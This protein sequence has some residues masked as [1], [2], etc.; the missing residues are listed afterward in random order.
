M[1]R[2]SKEDLQTSMLYDITTLLPADAVS[3]SS[4]QSSVNPSCCQSAV[5]PSSCQSAVNPPL[6]FANNFSSAEMLPG[7]GGTF[8]ANDSRFPHIEFG[9]DDIRFARETL[10]VTDVSRGLNR[11]K[12]KEMLEVTRG[13]ASKAEMGDVG[14]T[15]D[16]L[17]RD[18]G[19]GEELGRRE[20]I[21]EDN[22]TNELLRSKSSCRRAKKNRSTTGKLCSDLGRA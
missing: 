8:D 18:F 7:V 5:N 21:S 10:G 6:R 2:S 15:A 14:F 12:G 11:K 13:T 20:L 3:P 16:E 4:W 1:N 19:A 17:R 22:G 9:D